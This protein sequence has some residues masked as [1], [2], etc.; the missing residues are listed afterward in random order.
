MSTRF[1]SPVSTVP[2]LE[3]AAEAQMEDVAFPW[4]EV[5]LTALDAYEGAS[6][7]AVLTEWSELAEVNPNEVA[8]LISKAHVVDGRNILNREQWMSAGFTYRGVG[9]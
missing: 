8:S 6:V 4:I 3:A 5:S 9:R 7:L 1:Q 2:Q